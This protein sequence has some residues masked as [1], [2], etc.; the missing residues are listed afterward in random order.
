MPKK[1][2]VASIIIAIGTGVGLSSGVAAAGGWP[3]ESPPP[4]VSGA[5]GTV[6]SVNSLTSGCG[7]P[8]ASGTFTLS[9]LGGRTWTVNVSSPPGTTFFDP[10][11][12]SP[13]FGD[14]C[15]GARVGAVGTTSGGA[16]DAT[17]VFVARAFPHH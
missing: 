17:K 15:V 9:G 5:F 10:A 13:S 3:G 1:A 14:V 12:S 2:R 7:T 16:I 8:G 4:P 6:A 11:D